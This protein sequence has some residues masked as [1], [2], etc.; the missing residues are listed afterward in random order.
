MISYTSIVLHDSSIRM[1]KY[2][3]NIAVGNIGEKYRLSAV[4][5]SMD[6][7]DSIADK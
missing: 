4:L 2:D 7:I 6:Y 3:D 5:L 1:K